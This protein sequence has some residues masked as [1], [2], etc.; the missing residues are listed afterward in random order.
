MSTVTNNLGLPE[1]Y[2]R[3]WNA[4]QA[5]HKTSGAD[6][7]ATAAVTPAKIRRLMQLHGKEITEDI[8]DLVRP[9]IG[10]ALHYILEMGAT[11]ELSEEPLFAEV[12]GWTIVAKP[13]LL[14]LTSGVLTDHKAS[15]KWAYIIGDKKDWEAQ[16]NVTAEVLYQNGYDVKVLQVSLMVLDF[17][18]KER[19]QREDYPPASIVVV[20]VP[21]WTRDERLAYIRE[22]IDSHHRAQEGE[23]DDCTPAERWERPAVWAVVAESAKPN[24]QGFRRA[25]SGGLH[26]NEQDA[27]QMAAALTEEK[28]KKHLVEFRP[29]RSPR[30]EHCKVYDWCAQGQDLVAPE[31]RE[32]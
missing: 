6:L 12:D 2:R 17:S 11:S 30:C 13:D 16:L 25:V 21:V 1:V 5:N 18:K 15:S 28:K 7:S 9:L 14:E 20:P 22:R 27:N 3:A 23:I 26:D 29:G 8:S 19:R 32:V 10:T 31:Q 24:A 4:I